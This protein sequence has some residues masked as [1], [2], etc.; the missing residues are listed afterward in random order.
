MTECKNHGQNTYIP[1]LTSKPC[2]SNCFREIKEEVKEIVKDV[3]SITETEQ[4]YLV[5]KNN[6][7]VKSFN[8]YADDFAF[9]NARNFMNTIT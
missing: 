9:T 3:T 8:K 7:I 1:E 4:E 6:E 5:L 2:C